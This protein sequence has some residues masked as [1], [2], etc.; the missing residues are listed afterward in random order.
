MPFRKRPLSPRQHLILLRLAIVGVA[1]WA[2]CFGAIFPQTKYVQFW[3]AVTEAIFIGGAGIAVVGGLY[4]SRGTANGAWSGLFVGSSL[5]VTGILADLYCRLG[6]PA[7]QEWFLHGIQLS[8]NHAFV[9]NGV[10]VSFFSGIAACLAYGVV[11]LLTCRQPH[12]MDR[13]LHRGAYAVEPEGPPDAPAATGERV[14]WLRRIL[15]IDAQFNRTDRWITL[16]IFWWSMFW[17][18]VFIIG[19]VGYLLIRRSGHDSDYNGYWA[20]YYLITGICL[21]LVIGAC[22]TVWFTIGCWHDMKVFFRRLRVEAVNPEDDGTVLHGENAEDL[23]APGAH[24]HGA[25]VTAT[26]NP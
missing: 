1:L 10:Q 13:L 23:T 14:P 18:A 6:L 17:F 11:S 20:N 8:R 3:W 7:G 26:P 5:A 4:W 16:G 9:L 2:F 19:T 22:T 24:S 21:P 12:N 25:G 15:G